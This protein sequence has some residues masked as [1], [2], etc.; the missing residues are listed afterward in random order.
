MRK[1]GINLMK[2]EFKLELE[3]ECKLEFELNY[4]ADGT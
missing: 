2:F 3:F 1:F 4:H